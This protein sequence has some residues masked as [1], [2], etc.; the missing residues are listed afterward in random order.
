M[1]ILAAA[2]AAKASL[3]LL[4]TQK[5]NEALKKLQDEGKFTKLMVLQEEL[6]TLPFGEIW[7]E[8]CHRC[9]KPADGEW[10]SEIERYE[11]EVLEARA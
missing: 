9:G 8:Y 3:G 5:K 2:K 11:K 7:D 6:K 1:D 4:T 10:Y